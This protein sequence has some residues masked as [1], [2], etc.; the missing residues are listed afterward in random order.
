MS[1]YGVKAAATRTRSAMW[2]LRTQGRPE[3]IGLRILFYHRVSNDRDELAV[4]PRSFRRQMDY[5]A[6]QSYAVVDVH[7]AVRLLDR[8]AASTTAIWTSPNRRCRS[9]PSADFARP[10]SSRR[11]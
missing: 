4:T 10:S 9:W 8:G 5:L 1:I 11:E 6:S 7:E 3:G 2:F